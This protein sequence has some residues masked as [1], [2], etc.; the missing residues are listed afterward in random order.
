MTSFRRISAMISVFGDG[1][2][3]L[4]REVERRVVAKEKDGKESGWDARFGGWWRMADGGW[5]SEGE[6]QKGVCDGWRGEGRM[7]AA[8]WVALPAP[9][10]LAC[11][12]PFGWPTSWRASVARCR[13][14]SDL[15]W[16]ATAR[17]LLHLPQQ[18]RYI[19]RSG[20]AELAEPR[21]AH[22]IYTGLLLL[23]SHFLRLPKLAVPTPGYLAYCETAL[24]HSPATVSSV[25]TPPQD[26]VAHLLGGVE[27]RGSP[28]S[29]GARPGAVPGL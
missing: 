16:Q 14:G 21:P 5:R 2:L 26:P 10:L 23:L 15:A 18:K 7:L 25:S 1:R 8:G 24:Q 4:V 11:L 19:R 12:L 28:V 27:G 29:V 22:I 20:L 17:Y 3:W 6:R 13:G 9:S